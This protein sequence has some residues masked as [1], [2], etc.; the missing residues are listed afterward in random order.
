ML[1]RPSLTPAQAKYSP[2]PPR[3]KHPHGPI[4]FT[5]PLFPSLAFLLPS[6]TLIDL[7]IPTFHF[8]GI[9]P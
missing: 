4:L 8:S 5:S 9:S 7:L 1:L 2:P 6:L 3:R